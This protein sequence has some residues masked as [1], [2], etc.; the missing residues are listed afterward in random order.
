MHTRA[1]GLLSI[2]HIE[3]LDSWRV[4]TSLP[5]GTDNLIPSSQ[6][7]WFMRA[8]NASLNSLYQLLTL[9]HPNRLILTNLTTQS[10]P[11]AI[12]CIW[13][14]HF[15]SGNS[16]IFR[17][18]QTI[19]YSVITIIW[20]R[21]IGGVHSFDIALFLLSSILHYCNSVGRFLLKWVSKPMC[22]CL[23]VQVFYETVEKI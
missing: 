11:L 8:V 22:T 17:R 20:F 16:F 2:H 14:S 21:Y 15:N 7:I 10:K 23:T 1:V 3:L 5:V 6:L 4:L 13:C 18:K 12:S 19:K 9:V